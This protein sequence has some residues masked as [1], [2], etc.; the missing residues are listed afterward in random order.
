MRAMDI[1]DNSPVFPYP[2]YTTYV[3]EDLKLHS[4]LPLQIF[5]TGNQ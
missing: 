5:A 3:R 2:V 1:N 4:R